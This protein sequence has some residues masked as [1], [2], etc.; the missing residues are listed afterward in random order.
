MKKQGGIVI[1][2]FGST[3][4]LTSISCAAFIPHRL[5]AIIL[6]LSAFVAFIFDVRPLSAFTPEDKENDGRLIITNGEEPG[7]IA[8]G[9][10]ITS[11]INEVMH[12]NTIILE[13]ENRMEDGYEQD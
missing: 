9:L 12:K 10:Q 5:L 7:L 6:S 11:D 8:L 2:L 13:I 1:S 4:V 3:M